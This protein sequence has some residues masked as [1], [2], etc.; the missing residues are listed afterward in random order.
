MNGRPAMR[1][2]SDVCRALLGWLTAEQESC[3][4]IP[5][6]WI[7][8]SNAR[9]DLVVISDTMHAYEI[10]S[11]SDR[12]TR[13]P[14]QVAAYA[15]VFDRCSVVLDGRHVDRAM[16]VID[17][18]WGVLVVTPEGEISELRAASVNPRVLPEALVQLLWMDDARSVLRLMGSDPDLGRTRLDL[19]QEILRLAPRDYVRTAVRDTLKARPESAKR[20]RS[21]QHAPVTSHPSRLA[22]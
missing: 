22:S 12:L 5:E 1:T 4:A 16:E 6:F 11:S 19:W 21:R 20:F 2:G 13:L 14:A 8:G 15:T 17:P 18:W 10:K 3:R 7:P 9:A